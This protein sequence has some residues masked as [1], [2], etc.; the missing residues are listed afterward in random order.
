MKMTYGIEIGKEQDEMKKKKQE[1]MQ[2]NEP[3]CSD[4]CWR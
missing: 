1:G 4:N 3:I 2:K